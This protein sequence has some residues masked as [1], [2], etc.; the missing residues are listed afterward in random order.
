MTFGGFD[1]SRFYP[2]EV[3]F[4]LGADVSRDLV[5]GLQSITSRNSTGQFN[6]LLPSPIFTF[7]DSTS[8]YIYLPAPACQLFE[9]IFGL[10]FDPQLGMYTVN[11]DLHRALLASNPNIT[12]TIGNDKIGGSTVDIAL[13]YASFDLTATFPL[14]PNSTRYFPLKKAANDTQYTLGRAFLQEA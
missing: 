1:Q 10:V 5:V 13:P 12:F 7:V 3:S 9:E 14:V 4:S 8:P 2:N 11:D 6:S